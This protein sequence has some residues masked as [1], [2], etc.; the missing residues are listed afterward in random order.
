LPLVLKTW[1]NVR[2]GAGDSAARGHRVKKC[3]LMRADMLLHLKPD[4]RVG[5]KSGHPHD[6][7]S[8]CD[9]K[10]GDRASGRDAHDVGRRVATIEGPERIIR[11]ND[12]VAAHRKPRGNGECI[13]GAVHVDACDRWLRG[14]GDPQ[15]AVWSCDDAVWIGAGRHRELDPLAFVA[16]LIHERSDARSWRDAVRMRAARNDK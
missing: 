14:F 13:D 1:K 5:W 9:R 16:R 10:L 8:R 4:V 3:V 12:D 7:V 6:R 2:E 15:I 11:T